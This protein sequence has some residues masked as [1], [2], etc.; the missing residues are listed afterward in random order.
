MHGQQNIKI[1]FEYFIDPKFKVAWATNLLTQS[2]VSIVKRF[3]LTACCS[4]V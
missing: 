4:R 1:G 2:R 3:W